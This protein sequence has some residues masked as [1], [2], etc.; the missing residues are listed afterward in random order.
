MNARNPNLAVLAYEFK[1][2]ADNFRRARDC[3]LNRTFDLSIGG[4]KG[5]RYLLIGLVFLILLILVLSTQPASLWV[6]MLVDILGVLLIPNSALDSDINYKEIGVGVLWQF[7]RFLPLLLF[8]YQIAFR[9]ASLYLADIFEKPEQTARAFMRDVALGGASEILRIRDGKVLEADDG[10][11]SPILA[12]GGPGYVELDH[13]SVAL[14]E[15]AD[16][17]PRVIGPTLFDP[18][19]LDGFERFRTALDL[20]EQHIDLREQSN[21]EV[22]SRSLDGIKVSALDVSARFSI[23]RGEKER[24][25]GAPNPYRNGKMIEDMVYSQSRPINTIP[26]SARRDLA[27]P[28]DKAMEGF[29]RGALR[30]FMSENKLTEF[31]ASPGSPEINAAQ[32]QVAR[33]IAESR[34]VIPRGEEG[35]N[36]NVPSEPPFTPRSDITTRFYKEIAAKANDRGLELDWIDIGTWKTPDVVINEKHLEAWKLSAENATRDDER[37]IE[38]ARN[39][40]R[41]QKTVQIIQEVPLQRYHESLKANRPHHESVKRIL[42][43]YLE[44]MTET[45]ELLVK[46]DQPEDRELIKKL[47]DA[48]HHIRDLLG[49]DA[50]FVGGSGTPPTS[51]TS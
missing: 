27:Y 5:R 19:P 45:Y 12:F 50:H 28:V 38:G 16:G 11:E 49:W 3:V 6:R 30:Q 33:I 4:A 20:R 46:K 15:K 47:E 2:F 43:S 41:Q 1:A 37:A 42:I 25:L 22:P 32:R 26:E 14:F 48:I 31:L 39:D 9:R 24:T 40:A 8:P 18:I 35:P 21:N 17:R 13:N 29:I 36:P 23:W 51:F 34:R 7:I 10:G 44:Q